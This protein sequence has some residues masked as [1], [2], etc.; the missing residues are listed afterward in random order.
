MPITTKDIAKLANVSQSTV[1]RC[2]NNS[3]VISEKTKQRVLKIAQ[4][5]GF[6]FNASARSLSTSKTRTVGIICLK[7]MFDHDHDVHYLAWQDALIENLEHLEYDVIISLLK[8]RFTGQNNIRKLIT[9]RKID[10]LIILQQELDTESMAIL[11][12]ANI[13]YIF[14][15]YLP[16]L[17]RTKDVDY[18]HVDQFKGGYL[19]TQHLIDLGHKRILCI[20]A[21]VS[22]GEFERRTEGYKAAFQDNTL[23]FSSNPVLFGDAT[24][25]SGYQLI[26]DNRDALKGI[27]AIFGQ[28]DLMALGAISALKE[29]QINVPED[30]AV[31][32]YDNVKLCTYFQ[33]YLTSIHQP[34]EE[35]ALLTCKRLIESLTCGQS[36]VKQ[37]LAVQPKLIIRESCGSKKKPRGL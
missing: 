33:P 31:V 22:G 5:Q 24:F 20:S 18:V 14:C 16:T 27:T 32:G 36:S 11:E 13:P 23:S 15:K 26:K 34:F 17:C 12:E 10:G 29:M 30:I 37:R 6:Q 4:E 3:P 2:L 35:V 19:A 25:H 7:R 28:N 9:A 21:N 1:S 8:N